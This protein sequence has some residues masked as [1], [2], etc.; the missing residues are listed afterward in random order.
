MKNFK[1]LSCYPVAWFLGAGIPF[2]YLYFFINF[3]SLVNLYRKSH[4]VIWLFLVFFFYQLATTFHAVFNMHIDPIRVVAIFH[5]Y[6]VFLFVILGISLCKKREFQEYVRG[7]ILRYAVFFMLISI[8]FYFFAVYFSSGTISYNGVIE[9]VTIVSPGYTFGDTIPRLSIFGTFYNTTAIASVSIF[10]IYLIA[11]AQSDSILT[12]VLLWLMS[13]IVCAL[14]GSR[15][16][17]FAVLVL[18]PFMFR[19]NRFY[20]LFLFFSFLGALYFVFKYDFV[21]LVLNARSGSTGM[22]A[23]IYSLSIDTVMDR[24]P[25]FGMGHKPYVQ[26][27]PDYPLG[28]HSSLVGY[29]FK[30]GFV[31]LFFVLS[32][33]FFLM[34][35]TIMRFF[36]LI[37]SSKHVGANELSFKSS[38]VLLLV[39]VVFLFE[40]LD[41]FELNALLFGF[42]VGL[43]FYA[44]RV[45]GDIYY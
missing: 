9:R 6:V 3:S 31:G 39:S 36:R 30:N 19:L 35:S 17:V 15:I 11:R 20:L 22:R 4:V 34:I 38:L 33:Y 10:G 42:I 43:F 28:S 5:N 18:F 13:L 40:D 29:F 32:F 1:T 2:L 44:D 45:A 8:L 23:F 14:T 21:D 16:C 7:R 27:I 24:S 41:A 37:V 25:I 26:E 12:R